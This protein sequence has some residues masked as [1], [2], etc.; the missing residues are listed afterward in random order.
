MGCIEGHVSQ[1]KTLGLF[2]PESKP[3]Q[4]VRDVI[5][6]V[7]HPATNH[8]IPDHVFRDGARSYPG[9][10]GSPFD[11]LAKTIKAGGHGVPGGENMIR[12]HDGSIRYFTTYEAKLIQTFPKDFVIKGEWGEALRQIGN[13]VPV[14]LAERL[15]QSL[16]ALLDSP[17]QKGRP[18]IASVSHASVKR[19]QRRLDTNQM[20]EPATATLF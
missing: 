6:N 17:C 3:W 20:S 2:A 11:W 4:T 10:T 8:R 1:P 9:H 15:G 12:Y 14:I 13:A 5:G 16:K 19:P 18:A 7:P